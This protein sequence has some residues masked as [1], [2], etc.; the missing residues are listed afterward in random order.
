MGTRAFTTACSSGCLR[1]SYHVSPSLFSPCPLV[2]QNLIVHSFLPVDSSFTRRHTSLLA[3]LGDLRAL[4]R[5]WAIRAGREVL[6]NI[7][8]PT[9]ESVQTCEML[10]LYW[11]SAGE[12]QRNTMFSGMLPESLNWLQRLMTRPW[13]RH[14]VQGSLYS[15]A[16]LVGS[17]DELTHRKPTLRNKCRVAGSR[18]CSAVLLGR[19]VHAVHQLRPQRCRYNL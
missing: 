9:F 11:F 10:T 3:P 15:R 14:C 4:G 5:Q 13:S 12:S 16:R 8:Q 7:D 2:V 6:Q 18:S 17:V 19:L 1:H